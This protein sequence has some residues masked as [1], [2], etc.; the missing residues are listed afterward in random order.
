MP[1]HADLPPILEELEIDDLEALRKLANPMRLRLLA[2]FREPHSIAEVAHQIGVPPTRLYYHVNMLVDAG[3]LMI[4]DT[5]KRG[6]QLEKIYR[7]VAQSIRP[8][9][10]IIQ[11]HDVDPAVFAE[12]A[13][14]LVL[15]SARAELTASL[16]EHVKSGF[17]PSQITGALGRTLVSLTPDQAKEWSARIQEFAVELKGDD[18]DNSDA[19][20][21]G[22]T[23]SFFPIDPPTTEDTP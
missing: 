6:A 14:S 1:D 18:Q 16:T 19:E 10:G 8:A 11:R 9:T 13:A 12:V 7:V 4:V 21:Y 17:D 23:Y 3:V 5:R 15:D 20:V 22:F 2:S